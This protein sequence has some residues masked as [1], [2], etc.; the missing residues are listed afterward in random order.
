MQMQIELQNK[1]E[2][3]SDF[4]VLL[5][6]SRWFLCSAP[7]NIELVALPQVKGNSQILKWVRVTYPVMVESCLEVIF[8]D[9][10]GDSKLDQWDG[11]DLGYML[12][13]TGKIYGDNFYGLIRKN[14]QR[15]C[16]TCGDT[17]R[18]ISKSGLIVDIDLQPAIMAAGGSLTAGATHTFDLGIL[19]EELVAYCLVNE[20]VDDASETT[21]I[22]VISM[23][24]GSLIP[25]SATTMYLSVYKTLGTQASTSKETIYKIQ[26]GESGDMWHANGIVSFFSDNAGEEILAFTHKYLNEAVLLTNPWKTNGETQIL[27]RWG[28]TGNRDF[29]LI[30][31]H[32]FGGSGTTGIIPFKGVHNLVGI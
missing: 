6:L 16:G 19:N 26:Y 8:E 9:A 2:Q 14:T 32:D 5:V 1:K 24:T 29:P 20:H 7:H 27:Q 4:L 21:A 10:S 3:M 15:S 13:L 12:Q 30:V 22:V 17:I 11:L 28:T 23:E 31:A 25:I 18:R